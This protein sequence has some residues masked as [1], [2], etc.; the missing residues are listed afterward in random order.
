MTKEIVDK[1][2]N[3]YEQL[4]RDEVRLVQEWDEKEHKI[5]KVETNVE[6]KPEDND[7]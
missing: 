4:G 7:E 6:P 3:F 2:H 5:P 1:V